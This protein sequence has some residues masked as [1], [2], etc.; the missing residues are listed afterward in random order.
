MSRHL[1]DLLEATSSPQEGPRLPVPRV[2]LAET[3]RC[4]EE[5]VGGLVDDLVLNLEEVGVS[6]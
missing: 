3:L 1:T 2:F 5:A 6:E 4:M